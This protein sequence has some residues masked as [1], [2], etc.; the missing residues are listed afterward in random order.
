M[1]KLGIDKMEASLAL[2]L[3]GNNISEAMEHAINSPYDVCNGKNV[4]N[5]ITLKN[6]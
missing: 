5:A 3:S 1:T 4:K 6:Y 2:F